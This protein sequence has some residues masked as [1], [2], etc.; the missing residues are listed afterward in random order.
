MRP[1]AGAATALLM[2]AATP[3]LATP[4]VGVAPT[5]SQATIDLQARADVAGDRYSFVS[6]MLKEVSGSPEATQTNRVAFDLEVVDVADGRRILRYTVRSIVVKDASQPGVDAFAR[7]WT[8]IP[9]EFEAAPGYHPQRVLNW[10]RARAA[11]LAALASDPEAPPGFARQLETYYATQDDS[12]AGAAVTLLLG[13]VG[14]LAGMQLP[15][16]PT[17]RQ[18]LPD[19][20]RTLAGGAVVRKAW[21]AVDTVDTARC[22]VTFTRTTFH[23]AKSG[24]K[25]LEL[26]LNT[27]ATLSSH[28]GW[29]LK[30]RE[31]EITTIDGRKIDKLLTITRQGEAPGCGPSR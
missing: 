27:Q 30:L 3:V 4:T 5:A 25:A 8:G 16:I 12:G 21:I 1:I 31:R 17:A 10:P 2:A 9:I 28:D 29:V 15:E 14:V 11:F 23:D 19:E 7:A 6:E 20:A 24:K 18:A 13:D 22:E 26:D